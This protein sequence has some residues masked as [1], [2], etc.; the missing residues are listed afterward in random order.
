MTIHTYIQYTIRNRKGFTLVLMIVLLTVFLSI[1]M[2]IVNILLGQ[3]IIIGQAQ[4]SFKALYAADIA[5]E[6]T[7][8][9]DRVQNACTTSPNCT[10]EIIP[11]LNG[12]CYWVTVN[13]GPSASCT[14]P[15]TRCMVII[16]QDICSGAQRFVRRSFNVRY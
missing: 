13:V 3:V 14:G 9:R 12:A 6:R 10:T 2:G 4:E 15:S 8:Y 11:L 1:G 7:L 5:M 16:G